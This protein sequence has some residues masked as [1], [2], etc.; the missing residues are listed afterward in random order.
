MR[1]VVRAI[2]AAYLSIFTCWA[3]HPVHARREQELILGSVED[4]YLHER[5]HRPRAQAGWLALWSHRTELHPL[6][7][8]ARVRA[9]DACAGGNAGDRGGLMWIGT[10]VLVIASTAALWRWGPEVAV[11]LFVAVG[12]LTISWIAGHVWRRAARWLILPAVVLLA[13]PFVH[14]LVVGRE[15]GSVIT[16]AVVVGTVVA[17]TAALWRWRGDGRPQQQHAAMVLSI[18]A[19]G[20]CTGAL[21]HGGVREWVLAGTADEIGV[22]RVVRVQWLTVALIVQY[23]VYW[24]LV[25]AVVSRFARAWAVALPEPQEDQR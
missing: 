4:A 14:A 21:L 3:R 9:E 15:N 17:V 23:C 25:G 6:A 18:L 8:A 13:W 10:A 12:V 20:W 7:V 2:L 22:D 24:L 11:W 16:L 1:P 5:R 19:V